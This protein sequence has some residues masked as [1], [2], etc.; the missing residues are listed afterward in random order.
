MSVEAFV[1]DPV[2]RERLRAELARAG[3]A[4][5]RAHELV[6]RA[7]S[8]PWEM[9]E[10]VLG[11]GVELV[12]R[13]PIAAVS[14]GRS[15]A[16]NF[17]DTPLHSDSQL[18]RGVPPH[19]QLMFCERPA[20]R[21]GETLLLDAWLLLRDLRSSDP[22]LYRKLLEVPRRIPF[23]FGEVLGPTLSV[24]GG[25]LVFTHSPLTL[26]A[27]PIAHRLHAAV[28]SRPPVSLVME[29]GELLV[30]DNQR[31]LH[32]RT[33]FDDPRRRF[34][35][36]LVWLDRCLG[37]DPLL[38]GDAEL[39]CTDL[40]PRPESPG[41]AIR[42]RRRAVIDMLRGVPPGVIAARERIAEAELYRMREKALAGLDAALA[43]ETETT[44]RA[45]P[46]GVDEGKIRLR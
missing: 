23:V 43:G 16:S 40:A 4:R 10:L 13:Q 12:E 29:A 36:V 21:G 33:R 3:F 41:G 14:H 5:V 8:Q 6:A 42:A 11:D 9:A 30:V 17:A 1:P 46:A 7:A 2:Q 19:A 37:K 15:F 26:P 32:G 27:D 25:G 28:T 24:R 38:K 39:S 44:A 20:E 18:W 34:T 35:R 31:M 45:L 22:D